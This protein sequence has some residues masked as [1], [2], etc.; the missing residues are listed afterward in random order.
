MNL[1]N[2]KTKAAYDS[3]NGS[4]PESFHQFDTD[5]FDELALTLLENNDNIS[6]NEIKNALGINSE[7]WMVDTYSTRFSTLAD[8]YELMLNKGYSK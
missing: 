6:D 4:F 7:E 5:R 1:K 8:M 3:W 2:E